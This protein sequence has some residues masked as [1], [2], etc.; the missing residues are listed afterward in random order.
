MSALDPLC[1]L[2]TPEDELALHQLHQ[3]NAHLVLCCCAEYVKNRQDRLLTNRWEKVRQLAGTDQKAAKRPFFGGSN[4]KGRQWEQ[5]PASANALSVQLGERR[6]LVGIVPATIGTIVFDADSDLA[7]DA[8]RLAELF[9]HDPLAVVASSQ[10]GRGHIWY[11]LPSNHRENNRVYFLEGEKRGEIRAS[12]GYILLWRPAELLAQ[13][14]ENL[15]DN[16]PALTSEQI[17]QTRKP[18]NKPAYTRIYPPTAASQHTDEIGHRPCDADWIAESLATQSEGGRHDTLK[19]YLAHYRATTTVEQWPDVLEYLRPAFLAAKPEGEHEFNQ[20][21]TYYEA[22]PSAEP[23]YKR[24]PSAHSNR[25]NSAYPN[26]PTNG[27]AHQMA[28]ESAQDKRLK[29]WLT[30][31]W[32]TITDTHDAARLIYHFA[33]QL[34]IAYDPESREAT[35]D[36]YAIAANG[37]LSAGVERLQEMLNEVSDRYLVESNNADIRP[38]EFGAC[39]KA[40][41][42]LRTK[43]AVLKPLGY[44][45][46]GHGGLRSEARACCHRHW[47][48]SILP[49]STPI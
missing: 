2:Y 17:E 41:R 48:S 12:N 30:P 25:P 49:R 19:S 6:G 46:A 23:L 5:H 16:P 18:K 14:A 44:R 27:E 26:T 22:K 29:E 31:C 20:L 43:L 34:V 47:W 3:R 7:T 42:A 38:A 21:A 10:P 4:D 40:A 45:H 36:I 35:S 32:D 9:G 39:C 24:Y 1:Y 13:L 28:K 8:A 11:K 15:A 37:R 33:D